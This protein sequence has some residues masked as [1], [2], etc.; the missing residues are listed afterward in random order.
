MSKDKMIRVSQNYEFLEMGI[1]SLSFICFLY[2][3]YSIALDC[4]QQ[5]F[6][7]GNVYY[8]MDLHNMKHPKNMMKFR[9]FPL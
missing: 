6:F 2:K 8:H 9:R 7:N 4:I 1:S 3:L 5:F